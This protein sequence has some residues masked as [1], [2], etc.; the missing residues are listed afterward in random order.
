MGLRFRAFLIVESQD[1]SLPG[2][3]RKLLLAGLVARLDLTN[4]DAEIGFGLRLD[5]AHTQR[6]FS[7]HATAGQLS[8]KPR[9]SQWQTITDCHM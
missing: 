5:E 6:P 1:N 4:G 7:W 2:R 9:L 8:A 3:G